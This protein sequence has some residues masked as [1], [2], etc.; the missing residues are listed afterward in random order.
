MFSHM[1]S[2]WLLSCC[3]D[4]CQRGHDWWPKRLLHHCSRPTSAC[5]LMCAWAVG[6]IYKVCIGTR[7]QT[8]M[9]ESHL[10]SPSFHWRLRCWESTSKE[11][12]FWSKHRMWAG[13][14][15]KSRLGKIW[16]TENLF[17]FSFLLLNCYFHPL[18]ALKQHHI[19]FFGFID[20]NSCLNWCSHEH[21][22][23]DAYC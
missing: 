3:T 19:I 16:Q 6:F 2:T 23:I 15:T 22:D 21:I 18:F 5:S 8:S 13:D 1:W 7:L 14:N 4:D 12:M 11:E 20:I 17:F 10:L 9:S